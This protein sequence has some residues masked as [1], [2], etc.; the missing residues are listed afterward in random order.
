MLKT[1]KPQIDQVREASFLF[2]AYPV[3]LPFKPECGS[4]SESLWILL[5][6]GAVAKFVARLVIKT[7]QVKI[8]VQSGSSSKWVAQFALTF[9][10]HKQTNP[11]LLILGC[12]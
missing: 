6:P 1:H 8:A 5:V 4:L 12:C 11:T 9:M 2:V 10:Y 3:K 7:Q